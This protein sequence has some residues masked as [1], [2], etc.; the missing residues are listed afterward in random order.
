MILADR[1]I[2]PLFISKVESIQVPILGNICVS[3]MTQTD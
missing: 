1:Y 2:H 3:F